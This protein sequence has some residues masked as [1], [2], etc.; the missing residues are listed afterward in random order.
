MPFG[1][2]DEKKQNGFRNLQQ[3]LQ[4]FTR[5]LQRRPCERIEPGRSH[6]RDNFKF[7]K[8]RT[9]SQLSHREVLGANM[10]IDLMNIPKPSRKNNNKLSLSDSEPPSN[11][12]GNKYFQMHQTTRQ[13]S[14]STQIFQPYSNPEKNFGFTKIRSVRYNAQSSNILFR[15]NMS[16]LYNESY[17]SEVEHF[18]DAKFEHLRF[19]IT[20]GRRLKT[21]ILLDSKRQ[22]QEGE[23][24]ANPYRAHN[25]S[26]I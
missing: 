22:Y 5:E 7:E 13:K 11:T 3:D 23:L 18:I 24:P 15:T 19:T 12:R 16:R 25:D 6:H 26:R 4:E 2:L 1:H 9:I 8:E 20:L 21:Q 14:V 10:R 17:V